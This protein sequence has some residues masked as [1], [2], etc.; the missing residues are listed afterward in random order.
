MVKAV[1]L[2]AFLRWIEDNGNDGF[3]DDAV[4]YE[5]I[6]NEYLKQSVKKR[7]KAMGIRDCVSGN[8]E[9]VV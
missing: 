2:V 6:A 3:F 4:T 8:A 7:R 9:K 5:D 1:D